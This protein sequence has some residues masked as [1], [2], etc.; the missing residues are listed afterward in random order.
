[1][2]FHCVATKCDF[3]ILVDNAVKTVLHNLYNFY[4]QFAVFVENEIHKQREPLEREFKV[5]P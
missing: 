2:S 4:I 3:L 1:M 5:L